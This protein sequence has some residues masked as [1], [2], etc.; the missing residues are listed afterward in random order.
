[1]VAEPLAESKQPFAERLGQWL[2]F[3]DAL[4]LYAALNTPLQADNTVARSGPA[5]SARGS[6]PRPRGPER[7]DHDGRHTEAGQGAGRIAHPGAQGIGRR[8][9][10]LRPYHRY[11][12]AHQRDMNAVIG[13]L[14]ARVRAILSQCC[15]RL[16]QLAE[17][18]AL[19]DQ[20]LAARERSLLATVPTLLGKRFEALFAAHQAAMPDAPAGRSTALDAARWLAGGVLQGHAGGAA[21]RARAA[22]AAGRGA[23]RGTGQRGNDAAMNRIISWRPL[24]SAWPPYAGSAPA[25]GVS[26]LALAMTALIGAVY[27]AGAA[28]L[29]R[30]EQGTAALSQALAAIPENLAHPG[31][32]LRTLPPALQNPVRLRIEGE[33]VGLPGPAVTPYLVGLLVLLGMLGTFLGMVVTLN[34]AVLA[35]ESTT[36]LQTIRASLAA[37]VKGLGVAFGTSVAGVAAS[38]MLGLLSAMSR[39]T[40]AQAGQ[41]LDTRIATT[42]RG[43]ARPATPRNLQGAAATGGCAACGGYR[44]LDAMMLQ[45]EH[46]SVQINERLLAEQGRFYSDTRNMYA[47]LA[48][49]VGDSLGRAS[50]TAPASRARPSARRSR[51]R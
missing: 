44:K 47:Q 3:A 5:A 49:S 16:A 41:L 21:G 40:R 32:W 31:E 39:R 45:L 14:R 9:R 23:D 26:T 30:F 42:L 43:F 10:R 17:L 4:S 13:P 27:L 11:Y 25:I 51:P 36:D 38:A 37:P 35:L 28:E 18:D 15:P 50:P 29:L 12:A 48:S 33:R 22:T 34:G 1:M 7:V 2:D 24:Q 20:A 6:R 8:R 46:H 19:M